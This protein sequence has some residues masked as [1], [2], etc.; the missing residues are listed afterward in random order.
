MKLVR[1]GPSLLKRR[2]C[3]GAHPK[4]ERIWKISSLKYKIQFYE[5]RMASNK[6]AIATCKRSERSDALGLSSSL[7]LRKLE[8]AV[9]KDEFLG[10][11]LNS[12]VVRGHDLVVEEVDL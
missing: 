2:T 4:K 11:E 3:C 6:E 10:Q 12:L 9:P 8:E 5:Q 1:F 7:L